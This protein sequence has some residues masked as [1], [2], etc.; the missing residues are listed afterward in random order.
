[1]II[2]ID[3]SRVEDSFVFA[4]QQNSGERARG[5][6]RKFEGQRISFP[7]VA[8]SPGHGDTFGATDTSAIVPTLYRFHDV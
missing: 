2:E 7:L 3:V 5:P 6:L 8:R 4:R 1:L